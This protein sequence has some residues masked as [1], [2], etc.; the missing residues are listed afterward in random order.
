MKIGV[1]GARGKM[2]RE[3][4]LILNGDVRVREIRATDILSL[5]GSSGKIGYFTG[6]RNMAKGCSVIIDFSSPSGTRELLPV[7]ME[8]KIALVIGTTGHSKEELN[9]ISEAAQYTPIVKATNM[10]LSVNVM[11][12]EMARIA[13]VLGLEWDAEIIEAHHNQKKDAPSG[14]AKTLAEIIA[15]ARGQVEP[16]K[17]FVYSRSG[18]RRPGEIGILAIRAGGIIGEHMVIFAKG[19]ERLEIKSQIGNR[20]DFAQGA[21]KAAFWVNNQKPGLYDMMDVL[22]LG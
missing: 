7:A 11:F 16:E 18:L 15:K 4:I 8:A 10:S 3:I 20:Q 19:T 13:K 12:A 17:V 9:Q 5:P 6:I 21:V 1:V 2:G 22:G 14:T